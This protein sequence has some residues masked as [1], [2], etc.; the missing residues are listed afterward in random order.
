MF[1]AGV[2]AALSIRNICTAGLSKRGWVEMYTPENQ[3][4]EPKNHPMEKENHLNQTSMTL[5]SKF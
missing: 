3:H 4:V 1:N 2:L 5:G